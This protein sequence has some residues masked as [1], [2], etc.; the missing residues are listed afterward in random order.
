MT[1]RTVQAYDTLVLHNPKLVLVVLLSILVFFGYYT[2]DFKL[3]ASAD[4]LLLEDDVDL[5]LFR[6]IHQRYPSSDLLVVTYTP[7]K[8]L[9]SDEALEPLKQLREELKKVTSVDTVFTILDAPLIK[10]SDVPITK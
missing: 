3:D 2:K 10:S 6:K 7:D 8:D 4:S 5:N 1:S 9:F